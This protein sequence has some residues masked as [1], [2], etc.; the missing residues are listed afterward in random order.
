M[1]GRESVTRT[2]GVESVRADRRGDADHVAGHGDVHVAERILGEQ[3]VPAVAGGVSRQQILEE[4]EQRGPLRVV[5]QDG[6]HGPEGIFE[7]LAA[8]APVRTDEPYRAD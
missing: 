7:E 4:H 8:D 5:R 1:S 3:R 2:A 6:A